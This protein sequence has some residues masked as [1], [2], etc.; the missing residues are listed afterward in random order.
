MPLSPQEAA[1]LS[2]GEKMMAGSVTSAIDAQL[3]ARYDGS[4]SFDAMFNRIPGMTNKVATHII[5]QYKAQGWRGSWCRLEPV[6]TL[7]FH[8]RVK[9]NNEEVWGIAQKLLS[10]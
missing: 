3:T 2:M 8:L 7:A 1:S 6:G 9:E 10:D 5:N 4:G